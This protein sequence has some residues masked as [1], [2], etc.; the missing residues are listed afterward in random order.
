MRTNIA[1]DSK[2]HSK[3]VEYAKQNHTTVY[4]LGNSILSIFVDAL[5][6]GLDMEEIRGQT[7]IRYATKNLD[8]VLLPGSL[9]E[10]MV[11]QLYPL[12][13]EE[14]FR[15]FEDAGAEL[16]KYFK[17]RGITFDDILEMAKLGYSSIG[18]RE[19]NMKRLNENKVRVSIFGLLLGKAATEVGLK[20]VQGL[21]NEFGF[22]VTATEQAEGAVALTFEVNQKEK[23]WL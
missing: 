21:L 16:G 19:I 9:I 12:R 22:T 10:Y 7:L 23:Q 13:R 3:L 18:L 1:V 20:F 8:V 4:E 5:E 2:I 14:M 15:L 17:I 6:K 11:N